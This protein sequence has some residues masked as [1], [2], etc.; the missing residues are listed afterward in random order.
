MGGTTHCQPAR[1]PYGPAMG[2]GLIWKTLA[3]ATV[4]AGGVWLLTVATFSP[5]VTAIVEADGEVV[6]ADDRP[7]CSGAL[8][9]PYTI[10]GVRVQPTMP[11]RCHGGPIPA[12][13]LG[14]SP[15]P[16]VATFLL[17]GSLCLVVVGFMLS[18]HAA[19]PDDPPG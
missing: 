19:R 3:I 1:K 9:I 8:T 7:Y 13:A 2:T 16:A 18:Y 11:S 10:D 15:V 5:Q 14:P 17:V 6:Y 4:A 12:S